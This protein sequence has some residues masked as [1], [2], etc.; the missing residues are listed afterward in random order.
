MSLRFVLGGNCV[1]R[2]DDVWAYRHFIHKVLH[3]VLAKCLHD[4][5]VSDGV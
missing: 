3:G 2:W 5:G 4:D 1:D